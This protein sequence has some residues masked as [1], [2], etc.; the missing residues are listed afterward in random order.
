MASHAG[1]ETMPLMS[2]AW[3][4]RRGLIGS[5]L[6]IGLASRVACAF[7]TRPIRIVIGFGPGGLADIIVRLVAQELADRISQQVVVDNRPGAGGAIAAQ[8][9]AGAVADGHTLIVFTSGTAISKALFRSLSFDPVVQFTPVTS[10]AFFDAL[11]MAPADGPV[12]SIA[13]L[14]ARGSS[15]PLTIGTLTA[16]TTQ[17]LTGEMFRLASNL[18]ITLV[19]FRT[20]PE[21]LTALRRRDVDLVIES[22]GAAAGEIKAGTVR[23]LASTG[24]R[25]SRLT[26]EVPTISESGFPDCVM[27]GWNAIFAPAG[28]PR[29]VIELL[30]ASMREII[31]RPAVQARLLELGVEGGT[32]S[33]EEMARLLQTEIALWNSVVDRA[34]IERQ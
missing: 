1:D 21:V 2:K 26:P 23:V 34:G 32:N 27:D 5:G 10:M 9:V 6:A 24:K 14:R 17:Y 3:L 22:Y 31:G 20:S 11:L 13:D 4:T 18:P 16:G 33:P 7:P 30:N 29:E 19:P 8:A 25:R 12:R 15:Q 28:T